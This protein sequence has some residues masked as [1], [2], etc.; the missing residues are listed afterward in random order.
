MTETSK[1]QDKLLIRRQLMN[2]IYELDLEISSLLDIIQMK[3]VLLQKMDDDDQKRTEA[4]QYLALLPN[5]AND[6]AARDCTDSGSSYSVRRDFALVK[7]R[8]RN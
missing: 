7:G 5:R 6:D 3:K 8:G 2:D 1:N 4:R